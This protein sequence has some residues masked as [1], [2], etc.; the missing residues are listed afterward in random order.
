M[1]LTHPHV[2]YVRITDQKDKFGQIKQALL[3]DTNLSINP[4]K[5]YSDDFCLTE[6]AAE[7]RDFQMEFRDILGTFKKIEV[8][9]QE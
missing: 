4:L 7:I 3:I 9:G 1:L 2:K 8:F 5:K 6:I